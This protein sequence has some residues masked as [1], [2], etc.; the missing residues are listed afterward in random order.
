MNTCPFLKKEFG[1]KCSLN[2]GQ[3]L[4]TGESETC[5]MRVD[6]ICKKCG[7]WTMGGGRTVAQVL[8]EKYHREC[9]GRW[10]ISANIRA[11][12]ACCGSTYR[13]KMDEGSPYCPICGQPILW[14]YEEIF[15]YT[16]DPKE[17]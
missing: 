6:V 5:A 1:M 3:C 13:K 17:A 15:K 4:Y 12:G 10:T 16:E 9:G 11:V 2:D 14:Q 7:S 8:D